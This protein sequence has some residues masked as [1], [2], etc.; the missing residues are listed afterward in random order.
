MVTAFC[1][2]TTFVVVPKGKRK[3]IKGDTSHLFEINGECYQ[4]IGYIKNGQSSTIDEIAASTSS[5]L[6]NGASRI[7]QDG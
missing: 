6:P 4:V 3:N 1:K 5:T 2:G 7:L